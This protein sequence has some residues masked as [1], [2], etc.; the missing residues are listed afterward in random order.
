MLTVLSPAKTLDYD[1]S[2]ATKKSSLPRMQAEVKEL[3]GV[4][5]SK[6]PS[7]LRQMMSISDDL[8][9]LNYERFQTFEPDYDRSNS[10]PAVLA[11]KGDVYQG[12]DVDSFTERDFTHAQKHLRIL[13]GLYGVLRPLDLMQPYRLEMG[14]RLKTEH[15]K[16]LYE[17]W[18]TRI[19]DSLNADLQNYRT[20]VLVNLAS[21]EYFS[22]VQPDHL[23]G[24]VISPTFKD[25]NRGDYRIISFFAKRARGVMAA[26]MIQNRVQS[27]KTL[28]DFDGMGYRYSPEHSTTDGPTFI[29]EAS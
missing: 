20:K 9:V 3:V 1:S 6:Q 4:M 10:R 16:D 8:A 2:L 7:D 28:R 11:F 18:G 25:F 29:R 13:S 21:K 24:R 12:L 23:D 22:A 5:A 27:A 26:W 15:G 19:T 14:S 17:Y